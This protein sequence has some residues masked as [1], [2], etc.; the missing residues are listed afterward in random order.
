MAR[1][2]CLVVELGRRDSRVGSESTARSDAGAYNIPFPHRLA[3]RRPALNLG[4]QQAYLNTLA[5]LVALTAP[6]TVPP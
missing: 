4:P 5:F 3:A 6:I 2:P 1:R